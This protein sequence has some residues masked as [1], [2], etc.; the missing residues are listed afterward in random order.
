MAGFSTYRVVDGH[1]FQT[2]TLGQGNIHSPVIREET[3]TARKQ[4]GHGMRKPRKFNVGASPGPRCRPL[5]L[6][7]KRHLMRLREDAHTWNDIA[8]RFPGRKRGTLQRI[9]Y[10]QLKRSGNQKPKTQP[11]SKRCLFAADD[12]NA[13]DPA[14]SAETTGVPVPAGK[15]V[16]CSR[17]SFRP[18][19][20][21]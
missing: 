21:I 14:Q 10:A 2:L 15:I 3:H 8:S 9:Y 17:Y 4:R 13:E 18:R 12:L 19:R 5:S 1:L 16:R 11:H 6:K 20:T 7:Q